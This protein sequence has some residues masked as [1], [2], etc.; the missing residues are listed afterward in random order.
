MYEDVFIA[1]QPILDQSGAE[2]AYELLFRDTHSGVASISDGFACTSAVVERAIGLFGLD[3]IVGDLSAFINC[4]DEFLFSD[5]VKLLPP[6]RFVLEVLENTVFTS[7]LGKRCNE[8]RELGYK[9][10][11]DDVNS[12]TESINIFLPFVD[13][14]KLDWP[15]LAGDKIT[16]ISFHYRSAGKKILAEKI[17]SLADHTNAVAAKCDLFQGF[18]FAR[19]QVLSIR[20][21][22]ARF[23]AV[24][25]L[26]ELLA[27]EANTTELEQSL[28]QAPSIV[29]QLLRLANSGDRLKVRSSPISSIRHALSIVG[30]R[31]LMRWCCLILYSDA[32]GKLGERDPLVRMVERRG[33]FMERAANDLMPGNAGFKDAAYLTGLLS[34]AHVR[35]GIDLANFVLD[36]P[37]SS[38]IQDALLERKG[39][40]GE[41]LMLVE[42]LEASKLE[43]SF[44]VSP[45]MNLA[46]FGNGPPLIL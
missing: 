27:N 34:L 39:D 45:Q 41:L 23:P 33:T 12:I 31:Q 5:T 44:H 38:A 28:R 6:S 2:V 3:R 32:N 7:D 25:R 8:L 16:K 30:S 20:R 43:P 4:S 26:L 42:H 18:F 29:I 15:Y 35:L 13:I 46:C 40:L 22:S 19:P 9:I 24:F 10:A 21:S 14:V 36:L 11:L 1:R 17:E 37:V